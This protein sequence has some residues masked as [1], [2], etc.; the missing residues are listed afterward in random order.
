MSDLGLKFICF[1]CQWICG[2]IFFILNSLSSSLSPANR[3]DCI[4]VSFAYTITPILK[5][6]SSILNQCLASASTKPPNYKE[7][8]PSV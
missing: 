7:D 6:H 5:M 4:S 1:R 2:S 3:F 8:M